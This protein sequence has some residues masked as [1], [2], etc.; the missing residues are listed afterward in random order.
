VR[1]LNITAII[2]VLDQLTKLLVKGF[3]LPLCGYYHPGLQIG[4]TVPVL[5]NYVR[6]TFI[7]NPGMA[8]G[9][10]I[11]S[12]LVLTIF[13]FLASAG[14]FWYLVS[15]RREPKWIR[16]SLALILGGAIGNLLDRM[17]YGILFGEA[18]FGYGK[19]VDFID[20][21]VLHLSRFGIF[22]VADAAVSI[23]VVLLLI[24]HRT[25]NSPKS[26]EEPII[27][28]DKLAKKSKDGR[29]MGSPGLGQ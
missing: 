11:G 1:V 2:V 22:N 23:G 29:D 12:Q 10:D 27:A 9:F 14:V 13:S 19:V 6:L 26:G 7:E 17:F 21:N 20:V 3:T 4:T 18:P 15:V 24:V 28:G 8:F 16:I 5:G 25:E